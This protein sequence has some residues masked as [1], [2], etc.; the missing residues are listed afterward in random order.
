MR[1]H[2]D[3]LVITHRL[4]CLFPGD[5]RLF[6]P[7]ALYGE[8]KVAVTEPNELATRI[9][10]R[11]AEIWAKRAT[12]RR[13]V[14]HMLAYAYDSHIRALLFAR[15]GGTE[16]EM[17]RREIEP[18]GLQSKVYSDLSLPPET[19]EAVSDGWRLRS[20]LKRWVASDDSAC[21][22]AH[23]DAS[24]LV[25]QASPGVKSVRYTPQKLMA[26]LEAGGVSGAIAEAV[27]GCA[28]LGAYQHCEVVATPE[29]R[30]K[31]YADITQMSK[32]MCS[33][34]SSREIYF[35]VAE[36]T[37]SVMRGHPLQQPG[38]GAYTAAAWSAGAASRLVLWGVKV[39]RGNKRAVSGAHSHCPKVSSPSSRLVACA[40][41][42][43]R[44]RLTKAEVQAAGAAI[45][46]PSLS[47]LAVAEVCTAVGADFLLVDAAIRPGPTLP[48][49]GRPETIA[50]SAIIRSLALRTRELHWT[51]AREQ[52]RVLMARNGVPEL[53]VTVCLQC[54]ALAVTARDGPGAPGVEKLTCAANN[55]DGGAHRALCFF[56]R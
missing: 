46:S 53:M 26:C 15:A 1:R 4:L 30:I 6:G 27:V 23:A 51:V 8:P 13:E 36:F 20:V 35:L 56:Y 43:G 50:A 19:A 2:N 16:S 34:L 42:S 37:S 21:S 32:T 48:K 17:F 40:A 44:W 49:F 10:A 25:A 29:T 28:W 14:A 33:E 22:Q 54:A 47:P 38:C 39:R 7:L 3:T 9:A 52:Q 55:V 18:Y 24:K 5:V 45:R 31:V 11:M 12:V 41:A